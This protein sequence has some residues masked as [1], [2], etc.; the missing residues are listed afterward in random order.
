M[1]LGRFEERSWDSSFNPLTTAIIKKRRP[2]SSE[3]CLSTEFNQIFIDPRILYDK[4][5][6]YKL[7]TP[8]RRQGLSTEQQS[9]K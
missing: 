7:C 8:V 3:I 5:G 2:P 1:V 6:S 4:E 9:Q